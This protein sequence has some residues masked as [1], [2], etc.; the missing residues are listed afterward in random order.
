M[1]TQRLEGPLVVNA[2]LAQLMRQGVV[3]SDP[4]CDL[5]AERYV[6]FPMTPQGRQFLASF[7][8]TTTDQFVLEEGYPGP[9]ALTATFKDG[10]TQSL[11]PTSAAVTS[12][13]AGAVR[14]DPMM[15]DIWF[16]TAAGLC[17]DRGAPVD[18]CA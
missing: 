11:F 1:M 8:E 17:T 12:V 5:F 6:L 10:H 9:C 15:G 7:G 2:Q 4:S 18:W 16:I 14:H 13:A 3:I